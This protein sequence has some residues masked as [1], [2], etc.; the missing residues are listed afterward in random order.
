VPLTDI[1]KCTD[2]SQL[3][4]F[5]N[6]IKE[7]IYQSKKKNPRKITQ[8]ENRLSVQNHKNANSQTKKNKATRNEITTKFVTPAAPT[9]NKKR[10][11][12]KQKK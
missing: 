3:L 9:K 6:S 11:R 12:N 4:P 10:K 7:H 5:T 1:K 8:T 2:P